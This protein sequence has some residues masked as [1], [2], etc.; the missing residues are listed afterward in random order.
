VNIV[1]AES[2]SHAQ[3]FATPW[4]VTY[5][6]PLSLGFS[7]QEYWSGLPCLQQGTL[8]NPGI[9]P[10]SLTSPAWAGSFFTTSATWEAI[11]CEYTWVKKKTLPLV[12]S[13]KK[14]TKFTR[15]KVSS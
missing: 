2:L 14:T 13:E 6:V 12:D 8:P 1:V 7:R 9:K 3:L 4:T 15:L 10:T 11:K 5:Q